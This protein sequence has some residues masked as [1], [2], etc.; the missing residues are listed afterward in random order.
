MWGPGR[1]TVAPRL[2]STCAICSTSPMFGTFWST[3]SS[4]T[5]RAAAIAPRVAFF[6]PLT[7]MTPWSLCPP[8]MTKAY[9]RPLQLRRDTR[10]VDFRLSPL[11]LLLRSS[12]RLL[13]A[14][15]VDLFGALGGVGEDRHAVVAHLQEAAADRHV[16]LVVAL[17]NAHHAGLD[18]RE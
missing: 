15:H 2:R 9:E 17:D 7:E 4:A 13:R 8:S 18:H 10:Q 3:M 1:C 6:E 16:G 12:P 11:E 14:R 5:S